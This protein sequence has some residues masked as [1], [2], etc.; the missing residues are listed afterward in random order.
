[1]RSRRPEK[2]ENQRLGQLHAK[3]C[4]KFSSGGPISGSQVGPPHACESSQ[5]NQLES[6]KCKV[7]LDFWKSIKAHEIFSLLLHFSS[8]SSLDQTATKFQL[9]SWTFKLQ[10]IEFYPTKIT[11]DRC[12]AKLNLQA[13]ISYL[14]TKVRVD[15][16][17]FGLCV[18]GWFVSI[19]WDMNWW[20]CLWYI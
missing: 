6:N 14:S 11:S 13:S 5:S 18:I 7:D 20:M 16:F 4:S 12:V 17:H 15:S 19:N 9:Y 10:L 3:R 1:M 8:S 2:P